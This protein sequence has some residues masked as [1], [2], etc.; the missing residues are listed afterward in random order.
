MPYFRLSNSNRKLMPPCD[1]WQQE[2]ATFRD[3]TIYNYQALY[4]LEGGR[5]THPNHHYHSL[6]HM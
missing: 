5:G 1:G 6:V 3:P 2:I 4:S